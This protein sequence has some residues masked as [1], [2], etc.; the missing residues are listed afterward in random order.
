MFIFKS[1]EVFDILAQYLPKNPVI[2]EAGSY[3][4]RD[5][6]KMATKWLQGTIHAFEPVPE[7]FVKL[8]TNTARLKNVGYYN[9]ALSN[10][11]GTATFYVSEMPKNP[12]IPSQAGS[13]H[14]P[15]KRLIWSPLVFPRTIE[16][17]TV[18]LDAWAE[19]HTISH[20]DFLWLDMQGH[21]LSV[22][23]AAPKILQTVSVIF[24][25]VGFIEGYEDQ[26]T[27]KEVKFWL[28]KQGFTEVGRDF[29]NTTSWFFGNMLF[30][31]S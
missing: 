10:K 21:E 12:G 22:M 27:H 9:R 13:L 29:E 28:E 30:V 5:T 23:Q 24:T 1:H 2:V 25:E 31:R 8:K 16:V 15:K 4:G 11:I 7:L 17:E 6:I 20:V 18:T 19:K 3:D 14:K 26:P